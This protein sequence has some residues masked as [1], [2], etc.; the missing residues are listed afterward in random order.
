MIPDSGI[1]LST[2]NPRSFNGQDSDETR[3]DFKIRDGDEDL[4]SILPSVASGNTSGGAGAIFDP[5]YLKFEFRCPEE[6][7]SFTPQVN[8][9]YVFGS[10]EYNEYVFSRYNDAFGFFLNGE[11]IAYL[12]DSDISVTINNVNNELNSQY[13]IGNEM[14]K[15]DQNERVSP[16]MLIE[17]DGL[18]TELT[19]VAEPKPGWNDIK[20]VIGDVSD[21]ILDS[22]VL[23]EAGTFGCKE[24]TNAPTWAPTSQP[25]IKVSEITYHYVH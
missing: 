14:E 17:A 13:F 9:D 19:A 16:Y 6:S 25:S 4:T 24:R 23:L 11:N 8:F 22:W 15:S 5:C 18:T 1:I 20:L 2:G 12:P 10:E 3:T 21:G 7:D